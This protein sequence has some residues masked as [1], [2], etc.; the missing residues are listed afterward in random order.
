VKAREGVPAQ[1]IVEII[2]R[3]ITKFISTPKMLFLD[4]ETM[5]NPLK[6]IE[7]LDLSL[8]KIPTKELYK[9]QISIA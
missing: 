3:G 9:L 4:E 6:D 7:T 1:E 8:L 5:Q 2:A